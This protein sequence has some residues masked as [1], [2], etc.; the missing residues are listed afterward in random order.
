M[1]FWN[2]SHSHVGLHIVEHHAGKCPFSSFLFCTV[3]FI[4][5]SSSQVLLL[6]G[7]HSGAVIVFLRKQ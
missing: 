3:C 1:Q 4:L 6:N 2:I 7:Y 5:D